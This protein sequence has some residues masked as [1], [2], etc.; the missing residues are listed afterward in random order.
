MELHQG[1]SPF[2]LATRWNVNP[3]PNRRPPSTGKASGTQPQP[4]SGSSDSRMRRAS[5]GDF[6]GITPV[7]NG[8]CVWLVSGYT[9]AAW[10]NGVR[11][12]GDATWQGISSLRCAKG[13]SRPLMVLIINGRFLESHWTP[14]PCLEKSCGVAAYGVTACVC[15]RFSRMNHFSLAPLIRRGEGVCLGQQVR[16][17]I[18]S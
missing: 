3:P 4:F 18:S 1:H 15:A 7:S 16:L 2:L 13:A 12:C 8:T 9:G 10:R 6:Q 17:A 5:P 14:D 11:L